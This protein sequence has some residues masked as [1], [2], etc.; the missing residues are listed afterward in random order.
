MAKVKLMYYPQHGSGKLSSG[1][2]A[3]QKGTSPKEGDACVFELVRI[4]NIELKVSILRR[5]VETRTSEH[6][7]GKL[8]LRKFRVRVMLASL[9]SASEPS[10]VTTAL[11]AAGKYELQYPSFTVVIRAHHQL[12]NGVTVPGSFFKGRINGRMQTATLKCTDGSWPV[13]LMYYPQ[14]G[15]GKLSSGWRAFQKGTSLKEGD[16]CVFELVRIDNIELKVS[17]LRRNVETRV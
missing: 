14:H 10:R 2:R 4:D 1:W 12:K 8:H 6:Y 7:T 17:I 9:S 13:K 11:E 16:A 5:N 15:S 3:F